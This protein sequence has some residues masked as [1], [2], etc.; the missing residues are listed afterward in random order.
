MRTVNA[1]FTDEKNKAENRPIK[2]YKVE[3]YD[4]ASAH[5]FFAGWDVNV[6]F[7]G[8][9]YTAFPITHDVIS[10]NNRGAIDA[11]R[12]TVGNVSRLIQGY[13]ELYDF[14]GKKVI[15]KTVWA[16]QLA[17]ASA[18]IDDVFYIDS[19]V[20]DAKDV[21][22]TLTSKFDLL[23]I[24][25]PGR[26]YSRNHCG[27]KFKGTECGYAGAETSCNKTKQRCKELNNYRRFG[28]FPSIQ[29]NKVFLA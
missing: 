8:Q 23:D 28:G 17:D 5:L 15:I 4:G 10:E 22:F 1:T 29:A 2:L 18:Y 25:L 19:Y 6:T 27:W 14:R 12:V 21:V 9:L 24:D 11:V 7:D 16:D 13:L 26:R 20:A 3:N